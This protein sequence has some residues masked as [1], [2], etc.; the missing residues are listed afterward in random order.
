M[1]K[2]TCFWVDENPGGEWMTRKLVLLL[3]FCFLCVVSASIPCFS[4]LFLFLCLGGNFEI[5]FLSLYYLPVDIIFD[6]FT[7]FFAFLIVI[8]TPS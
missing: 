7:S 4:Y 2:D 3:F 5:Q 6:I 8:I 1:K